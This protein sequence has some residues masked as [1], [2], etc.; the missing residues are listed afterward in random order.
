MGSNPTSTAADLRE[1][2]PRQ[3]ISGASRSPGLIWW[4]QLRAACSPIAGLSRSYRAWSRPLR[5]ALNRGAHA[6]EACT[7]PFRAGGTVRHRPDTRQLTE[8]ITLS[9]RDV[10]ENARRAA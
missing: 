7:V 2:R 3:P 8:R 4:S 6:A 5:T 9:D 10:L 1:H